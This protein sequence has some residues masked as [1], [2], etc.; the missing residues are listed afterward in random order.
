VGE[1]RSATEAAINQRDDLLK[2]VRTILDDVRRQIETAAEKQRG[3]EL[4]GG[5]RVWLVGEG[6][7]RRM[8]VRFADHAARLRRLR[9]PGWV[10]WIEDDAGVRLAVVGTDGTVRRKE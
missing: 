2:G 10:E 9:S 5:Q 6:G 1:R 4:A 8:M 7:V 3:L